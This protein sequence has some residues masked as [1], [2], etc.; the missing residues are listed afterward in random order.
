MTVHQR[1]AHG[2]V[3]GQTHQS[4]VDG[5][6]AVG[7][8][9]A[10]HVAHAGGGLL[11]RLVAGQP[12]LVHGV[13]DAPVYGLQ[14]VPHVRQGTAYNDAHGVFDI[15]FFHLRNQRRG[16]NHLIRVADLFRVVVWFLRHNKS[17]NPLFWVLWE[18]SPLNN[19][20]S[21]HTVRFSQ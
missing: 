8:V 21:P 13:E 11:K 2:E 14:T 4:V 5:G 16:D 17:P 1:V 6:V 3:L 10:Q 18:G 19:P 20:N 12:V 9:P 15:G 7:V